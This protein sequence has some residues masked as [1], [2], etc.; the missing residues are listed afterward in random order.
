MYIGTT[1]KGRLTQFIVLEKGD[2]AEALSILMTEK[3]NFNLIVSGKEADLDILADVAFSEVFRKIKILHL[4]GLELHK[5]EELFQFKAVKRLEIKNCKFKGKEAIDWS[6]LKQ[7]EELFTNYSKRFENLFNHSILKTLFIEKFEE[8]GFE[9]PVN[10]Q[11]ETLSIEKSKNCLWDSLP[12]FKNLKTLYLVDIHS[13]VNI[14][15]MTNFSQLTD[16]D[17]T[18]CK[19]VENVIESL[20]QVHSLKTIFLAYMSDFHSLTP[21]KNLLHLQELTIENG[22]KLMDKKNIDFLHHM[23]HLTFSIDMKNC[24]I[25]HDE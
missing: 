3:N 18:S 14:T 8:E 11:L 7:L 16:I 10:H 19:N 23:P 5:S 20:S 1:T 6:Q 22:G 13:L 2:S 21:L 17:L 4:T 12:N 9:F 24:A 15:W 25:G